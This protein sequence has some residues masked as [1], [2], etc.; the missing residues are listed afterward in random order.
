MRELELTR[1]CCCWATA[2]TGLG[3]GRHRIVETE[4]GHA[5]H[6]QL[7]IG[8][9]VWNLNHLWPKRRQ[10]GVLHNQFALLISM[11]R[12]IS[13]LSM[14]HMHVTWILHRLHITKPNTIHWFLGC[15]ILQQHPRR[16]VHVYWSISSTATC[17]LT[18]KSHTNFAIHGICT[19]ECQNQ[20]YPWGCY[21]P[22]LLVRWSYYF[23][24]Y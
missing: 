10:R 14:Q 23:W 7:E 19:V 4:A 2:T 1:R 6:R 3:R 8:R 18:V 11:Y 13:S 24:D 17:P 15:V 16:T 12:T 22:V 9:K 20:H 21:E 5:S